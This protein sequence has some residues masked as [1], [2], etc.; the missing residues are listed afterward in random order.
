MCGRHVGVEWSDR[1]RVV[2][3]KY[4]RNLVTN[5]IAA[6]LLHGFRIVRITIGKHMRMP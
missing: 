6:K 4:G 5:S 3:G 2:D 1:I